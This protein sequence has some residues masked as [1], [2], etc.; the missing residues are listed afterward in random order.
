M[1]QEIE[2]IIQN[3]KKREQLIIANRG[4]KAS[5]NEKLAEMGLTKEQL[6]AM[7]KKG[8]NS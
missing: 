1:N 3:L 4:A 7:V 6:I 8:T 2:N 5:I